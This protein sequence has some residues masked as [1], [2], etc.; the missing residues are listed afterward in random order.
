MKEV[1]MDA[2][3]LLSASPRKGNGDTIARLLCQWAREAAAPGLPQ[4]HFLRDVHVRPCTA[5]GFCALHPGRCALDGVPA[6][7]AGTLLRA[8]RRAPRLILIAPIWFY[9]P[10]AQLK[11]L[12]D[13]AQ[14]F[15]EAG[16]ARSTDTPARTAHLIFTAARQNGPRLF[17]ASGLIL[18]CFARQLGFAVPGEPLTLRGLDG[19]DD[20]QNNPAALEQLRCW[21]RTELG[22]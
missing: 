1:L 18:R 19:P 8:I 6:D 11:A 17:E 13:R 16:N 9:G 7:Q 2:P 21:S 3:F 12:V 15:W 14:T 20:L 10:P 5:C 22:W 4:L